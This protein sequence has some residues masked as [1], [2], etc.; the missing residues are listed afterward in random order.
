MVS[1]C[2]TAISEH[3]HSYDVRNLKS[4]GK[5]STVMFSPDGSLQEDGEKLLKTPNPVYDALFLISTL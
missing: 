2:Y 4:R 3:R 5:L 1:T